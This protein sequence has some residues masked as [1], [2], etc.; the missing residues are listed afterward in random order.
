LAIEVMNSELNRINNSEKTPS[1]LPSLIEENKQKPMTLLTENKLTTLL[2]TYSKILKI[3]YPNR[4]FKKELEASIDNLSLYKN[5]GL[6]AEIFFLDRKWIFEG[7]K[8]TITQ[9]QING[10]DLPINIPE[11]PTDNDLKTA[12][13]Q[14]FKGSYLYLSFSN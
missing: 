10:F 6:D 1:N 3:K 4:N 7:L 8:E 5:N 12:F 11:I 9:L 2:F 14:C 13:K